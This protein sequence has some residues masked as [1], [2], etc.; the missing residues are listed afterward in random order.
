ML[1]TWV[2]MQRYDDMLEASLLL[3]AMVLVLGLVAAGLAALGVRAWRV[4]GSSQSGSRE[5]VASSPNRKGRRTG[6]SLSSFWLL[7]SGSWLLLSL[8]GCGDATQPDAVWLRTGAGP[9][10]VVYPRAI[11]YSAKD[12]T[13]FVVDRLGRVQQIDRGGRY[14]GEF[15]MPQTRLGKPVGVTVGPDG[16]LYIPDTHYQRVMVYKPDGTP[17]RQWGEAGTGPGQFTYPTD[18]AFDAKG[19]VFVS[20]YGDGARVQ[21]FDKVGTYLYAFGRFGKGDGEFSR[22]QSMLIEGDVV[23]VTDACNHRIAVFRT[24]GTFVRNMGG[25]GSGLG[26]FR[27]P[28]GLAR[29]GDGNL[30]VCEFGNSRVQLVDKET[31]RG[32]KAFGTSGRDPGQFAYPWAVAVD[33]KDRIVAVD[34]GNNRLQVFEF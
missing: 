15:A 25:I 14:L 12:D 16:N 1:M 19:N 21:V 22:P 20:E 24:D 3:M 8:P 29:A 18:I 17:V 27:F 5:P 13:F 10:E 31:G 6:T 34:S 11:D 2:H 7:A 9:D 28:Y 4:M 23:Y 30:V 32:L 26:Q 33:K